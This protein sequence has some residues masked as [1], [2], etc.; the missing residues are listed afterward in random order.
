MIYVVLD[1]SYEDNY[2]MINTITVDLKDVAE[3]ER[4]EKAIK[5]NGLEGKFVNPDRQLYNILAK[6]LGV[7]KKM[8]DVDTNEI[9]VM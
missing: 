4:I 6:A 9:D 8:I 7:D 1:H 2:F 3:K 5:E